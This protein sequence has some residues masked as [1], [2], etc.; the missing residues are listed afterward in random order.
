MKTLKKTSANRLLTRF[1]NEL[2]TLLVSDLINVKSVKAQFSHSNQ[3]AR[4]QVP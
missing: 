3:Q 4:L 1:D 2:K